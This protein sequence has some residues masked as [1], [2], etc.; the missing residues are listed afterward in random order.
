MKYSTVNRDH[1]AHYVKV[2]SQ[3]YLFPGSCGPNFLEGKWNRK[4]KEEK[5]RKNVTRECL[6]L[7]CRPND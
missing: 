7:Q 5:E 3:S 6:H 4:K 2:S 1:A